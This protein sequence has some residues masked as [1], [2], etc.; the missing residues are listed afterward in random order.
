MFLLFLIIATPPCLES[1][2]QC[3]SGNIVV[4]KLADYHL[5]RSSGTCRFRGILTHFSTPRRYSISKRARLF[6]NTE[7]LSSKNCMSITLQ[8]HI[9]HY[10]K[11]FA[12]QKCHIVVLYDNLL[13]LFKEIL[14]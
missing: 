11:H 10:P 14:D 9:S 6:I 8:R 13:K 1:N 5:D 3:G 7:D 12:C 4:F 2:K